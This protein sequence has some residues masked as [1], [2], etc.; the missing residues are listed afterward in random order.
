MLLYYFHERAWEK[1]SWG[2]GEKKGKTLF[3]VTLIL[4][5]LSFVLVIIVGLGFGH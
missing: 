3:Y 1:I 2:R 4:L 5:I